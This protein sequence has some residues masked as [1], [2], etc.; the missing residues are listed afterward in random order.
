[1]THIIGVD[2]GLTGGIALV[3]LDEQLIQVWEMPSLYEGKRNSIS[4]PLLRPLIH[5]LVVGSPV[6]PIA[7]IEKVGAMPGQG[8]TSMFNFG[9][10]VGLI[11]GVLTA[12]GCSIRSAPPN[13]WKAQM[14]LTGLNKEGSRSK[15]IEMF[16]DQAKRF[17]FKKDEGKAEAVLIAVWGARQER[18][19]A[20]S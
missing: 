9:R 7:Y 8:V 6:R 3:T 16:P 19:R 1:M 18:K 5:E 11:E 10:G 2:P 12:Y 4:G 14:G 13:R 20:D 15:V 17:E